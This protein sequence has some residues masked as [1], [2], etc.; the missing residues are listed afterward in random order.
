MKSVLTVSKAKILILF[1][2][3][4]KICCAQTLFTIDNKKF[5]D[6]DIK[7]RKMYI[8]SKGKADTMHIDVHNNQFYF[9]LNEIE[10]QD[11]MYYYIES[12]KFVYFFS[13]KNIN[14]HEKEYKMD[15]VKFRRCLKVIY[16]IGLLN[17]EGVTLPIFL[18]KKKLK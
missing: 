8:V 11:S 6:V 1:I 14:F 5:D 3:V 17:N 12:E 4:S 18:K 15:V 10:K 2:F 16:N 13:M 9:Y 7:I